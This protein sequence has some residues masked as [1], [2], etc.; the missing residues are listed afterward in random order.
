[1]IRRR[2][3]RNCFRYQKSKATEHVTCRQM[4]SQV[5]STGSSGLTTPRPS[6]SCLRRAQNDANSC[7]SSWPHPAPS[8]VTWRQYLGSLSWGGSCRSSLRIRFRSPPDPTRGTTLGD[9]ALMYWWTWQKHTIG[10]FSGISVC[11]QTVAPALQ[12]EFTQLWMCSCRTVS[13]SQ[14]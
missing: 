13:G 11:F 14:T 7:C 2:L 1:V 3:H 6:A 9:S 4:T 10:K 12:S 5:G 8:W